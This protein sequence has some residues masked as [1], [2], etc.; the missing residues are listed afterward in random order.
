M[1][2]FSNRNIAS[3]KSSEGPGTGRFRT[4]LIDLDRNLL[5]LYKTHFILLEQF[6]IHVLRYSSYYFIYGVFVAYG[7]MDGDK[8]SVCFEPFSSVIST[9][10]HVI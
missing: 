1:A 8:N 6:N 5:Y 2:G 10:F 3:M 7:P 9:S 4:G